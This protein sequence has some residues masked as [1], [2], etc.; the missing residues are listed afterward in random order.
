MYLA[1]GARWR[2]PLACALA[3]G[4]LRLVPRPK[5]GDCVQGDQLLPYGAK[6]A[7]VLVQGTIDVIQG[8]KKL[9]G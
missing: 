3:W 7:E 5:A 4:A 2:A 8:V 6:C 1:G 9:R